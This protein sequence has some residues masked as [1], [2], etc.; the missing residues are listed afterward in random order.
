MFCFFGKNGYVLTMEI[1]SEDGET[2]L[3][4][5][6]EGNSVNFILS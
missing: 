3:Y 2:L 5:N 4:S 6:N 1:G